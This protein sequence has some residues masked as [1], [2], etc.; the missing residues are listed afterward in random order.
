V[1]VVFV[2]HLARPAAV[3]AGPLGEKLGMAEYETR[4]ALSAPQPAILFS[5]ADRERAMDAVALLRSRGHGAY[6]FDDEGF[7]PSDEMTRLDDFRLD[8]DGVRRASDGALL[9]YGDIFAILRAM[10]ATTG[11]RVRPG[12]PNFSG[13]TGVTRMESSDVV[14][15]VYEREHVAYFFRRS[16]ERPWILR[17][18]H[19]NYAGLGADRQSIANSNFRVVLDRI[20]AA[21]PTAISDD[22]LV[23]R[24]VAE[25]MIMDTRIRTSSEGVDLLA[26]LLAMAIASQGGSPYR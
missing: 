20:R 25:R 17:E 9:P 16:A 11:T 3:E 12:M 26:H 8:T 15:R 7:V 5:T 14:T 6:A 2:S 21:C 18:R 4:L 19:A 13:K 23:H 1:H 22:R 10:H 24:R